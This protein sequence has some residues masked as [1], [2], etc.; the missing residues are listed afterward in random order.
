MLDLMI[1]ARLFI[2]GLMCGAL[3]SYFLPQWWKNLVHFV[4]R[5]HRTSALDQIQADLQVLTAQMRK[6]Q[7]SEPLLALSEKI[8]ALSQAVAQF[9]HVQ[10]RTKKK[11]TPKTQVNGIAPSSKH[12]QNS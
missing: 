3:A 4:S 12:T 10:S 9:P 1:D 7:H 8:D 11:A 6:Q 2:I 5:V